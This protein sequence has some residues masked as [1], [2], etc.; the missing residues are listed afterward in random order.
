MTGA[1]KNTV[2]GPTHRECSTSVQPFMRRTNEKEVA[3]VE[4]A[5]AEITLP[6]A[7]VTHLQGGS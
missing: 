6:A 4:A 1:Q 3:E 7:C 5:L 2:F